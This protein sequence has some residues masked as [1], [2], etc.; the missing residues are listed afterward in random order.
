MTEH[1]IPTPADLAELARLRRK[2]S[3]LKPDDGSGTPAGEA[4]EAEQ[5]TAAPA[6]PVREG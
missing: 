5:R 2:H 6:E 3:D 4:V 1:R